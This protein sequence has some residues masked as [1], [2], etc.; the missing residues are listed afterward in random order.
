MHGL[1]GQLCY[2]REALNQRNCYYSA[3][4]AY[5]RLRNDARE[6]L[7]FHVRKGHISTAASINDLGTTRQL[8]I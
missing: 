7:Y 4:V 3:S 6:Y 8:N 2:V 5:S 1:S